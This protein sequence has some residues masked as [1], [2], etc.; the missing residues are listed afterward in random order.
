MTGYYPPG[1][2]SW[3]MHAREGE[4]A[5]TE[6][7]DVVQRLREVAA[8]FEDDFAGLIC[9]SAADLLTRLSSDMEEARRERDETATNLVDERDDYKARADKAEADLERMT[10]LFEPLREL[11]AKG[12][13]GEWRHGR[14]DMLS[15]RASD[16][17]LVHFVYR[18][19]DDVQSRIEVGGKRCVNDARLIATSVNAIRSYFQTQ[20]ESGGSDGHD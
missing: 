20:S 5:M 10:A 1:D 19:D 17:E 18:P 4:A 14:L 6:T 16:G 7:Q 11:S 8:Q 12:T 9:R 15:Y 3:A 2:R 13:A